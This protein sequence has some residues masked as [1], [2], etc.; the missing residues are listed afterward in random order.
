MMVLAVWECCRLAGYGCAVRRELRAIRRREGVW[1]Y[2]CWRLAG[3]AVPI[4][5][6][7]VRRGLSVRLPYVE[8]GFQGVFLLRYGWG[9]SD[10]RAF[11]FHV[12]DKI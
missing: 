3:P 1:W 6:R 9:E 12:R 7:A 5:R 8:P 4:T 10:R 2:S 11:L